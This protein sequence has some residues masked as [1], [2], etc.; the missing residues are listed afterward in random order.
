[1]RRYFLHTNSHSADSLD[2]PP[3]VNF[4][5]TFSD[6]FQTVTDSCLVGA[7]KPREREAGWARCENAHKMADELRLHRTGTQHA[8]PLT[9][10]V[11]NDHE[12]IVPAITVGLVSLRQ[13]NSNIIVHL[14]RCWI[15]LRLTRLKNPKSSG[16]RRT[17]SKGCYWTQTRPT[18]PVKKK[19]SI[20]GTGRCMSKPPKRKHGRERDATQLAS[21][22]ADANK[23]S[24]DAPRHCSRLV[25]TE[26]RHKEDLLSNTTH[27]SSASS[28]LCCVSGRH[29]PRRKPL[30]VAGVS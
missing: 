21:K 12:G 28:T 4:M 15:F 10:H 1:M 17:M 16:K 5:K 13:Q 24:A 2:Q 19:Y 27:G 3:T 30:L 6:T 14:C 8:I 9:T 7:K 18:S 29:C 26:V 22:W 23:S 25:C 11:P 20:R